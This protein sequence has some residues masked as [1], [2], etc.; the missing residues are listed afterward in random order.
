[1][2]KLRS[3]KTA[4][5]SQDFSPAGA[6]SSPLPP[7]PPPA[8]ERWSRRAE[9]TLACTGY[10]VGLGNV[11]RFPYL[12][13][14]SGGG[15]FLLPY[16]VM[17]ALC[18]IPLLLMEM[19][20]GQY[21]GL[22]PV[23]ALAAIC[24]LFKGVGLA[25]VAISFLLCSYYNV[26]ITWALFYLVNSC[27]EP[28][29]WLSCN[30][31]WNEVDSCSDGVA[32][33][34]STLQSSSQQ[35]YSKRVLSM[36]GGLEQGG[37]LRWELFGLLILAWVLVY[38]CIF[39]GVKSTGKVVYFTA[40]F[41]YVILLALLINNAM[42]PGA[43]DGI[44]YYMSPQ[45]DQLLNTQV[46]VNAAAQIFNSIGIGFG[47]LIS[48][49]SYNAF[50]NN[51]I[52]DTLFVSIINSATS[53]FAG[54]VVFS[55]IGFMSH[56]HG[57]PVQDIATDGPGLVFVV[58]PEV[59]STLPVPPLWAVLF[60]FML[61]CLGLDSQFAM[62]EVMVTTL[63]DS[64]GA[65]LLR[66]L[67]RREVVVAA[68][69]GLALLLG[70]PNITQGGIY[71]FQLMDHYTAI[72]SLTF[73]ACFE[74]VAV[75]LVYGS[76]RLS[77][78][79]EEMLGRKPNIFFRLCWMVASPCLVTAILVF[80]VLQYEPVRYGDYVYPAWAEG[81]GWVVSL[82]SIGWIPLGM[83][84]T[85]YHAQGTLI[86]RLKWSVTPRAVRRSDWEAP[87]SKRR[88]SPTPPLVTAQ[89]AF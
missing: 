73:L 61:L 52:Q 71:F 25:T 24:P 14:R 13:Y 7:A 2:G 31:S 79:I 46:W 11:W 10:A 4:S 66:L 44:L 87:Q 64:Y 75:C 57:V 35:Y 8:R 88:P 18:G 89:T 17:L 19:S 78:N 3:V 45:W 1:M 21:T 12:C 53:I 27:Q 23:R 29:P 22:G 37:A 80:S 62:V 49:S 33:P 55:A 5:I 9:F 28:L 60:F 20:V 69:C 39:K 68:V 47:S 51:I 85:L 59:F 70:L 48:M 74:V 38:L 50:D 83:A 67:R 54:F 26:I 32:R 72:I 43:M 15:A 41:P 56:T 58:Y 6:A 42:L 63:M 16:L 82:L 30:N 84:H 86:Q 77:S 65:T 36:S 81:L 34:N 76:S 40:T